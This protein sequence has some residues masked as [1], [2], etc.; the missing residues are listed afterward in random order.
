[1]NEQNRSGQPPQPA[2]LP[3]TAALASPTDQ[4]VPVTY[5]SAAPTIPRPKRIHPRRLLPLIP[6]GDEIQDLNATP[7]VALAPAHAVAAPGVRAATDNVRLGKNTELTSPAESET[8]ST[9]G[10]P[11]VAINGR[12]ILYTGN[13]YAAISIDGGDTFQFIDPSQAFRQFDPPGQVFCCDQVANFIPSI[14]T[15][16][17]LLQYS[18][19]DPP[20]QDGDNIQRIA[21][22]KTADAA[23]GR[24]RLFDITTNFLGVRGGS[25][26]FPDLAVGE[27]MLYVTTN[28]F[29]PGV[30]TVSAV[31]RI[32]FA[33]LD[34]G[35]ITATPFLARHAS[36]RV[37]QNSGTTAFFASHETQSSVAVY[38]WPEAEA[39]PSEP[40]VVSVARWEGGNSG[41]ISRT[42]DRRRWLDRADFRMTGATRKGDEI[43]FAWGVDRGGANQRPNPFVQIARID[44]S[45]MTLIEN[46]NLWDPDSAICYAAL[47]TNANDE[48]GVSYMIGG[49][50]RF[51]SHVVGILT[52]T[53]KD[54]LVVEGER[55]PVEDD[56]SGRFQWGDYLA[57]RPR[58]PERKLFAA[59]GFTLQGRNDGNG[60]N[61]TP[62]FVLFGRSG[63]L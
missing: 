44:S 61:A 58:F 49:G 37:A 38:A 15:F 56:Q 30:R 31:V 55:S 9:V 19:I 59:T 57:V 14:D 62:R 39:R 60:R 22:A 11:S 36:V 16:V 23:A 47:S 12:T 46:I 13:W 6:E 2:G 32:P 52:G 28:V 48:V 35:N 42:P 33:G 4:P 40:A 1:M 53:R 20:G 63:D 7:Q 43:W 41:Y 3:P 18:R 10:E 50:L 34:S 54:V 24:W 29:R 45:N 27:N 21:F 8:A 5:L 25:L 17:W 51:P 26:D